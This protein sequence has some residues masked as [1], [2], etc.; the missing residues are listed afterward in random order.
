[1]MLEFFCASIQSYISV[2][3][4]YIDTAVICIFCCSDRK[5]GIAFSERKD[6]VA[7]FNVNAGE[8]CSRGNGAQVLLQVQ[9]NSRKN[10]RGGE[11]RERAVDRDGGDA[12]SGQA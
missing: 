9:G 1:M 4:L 12:G 8:Y 3:S 5:N 7:D 10:R 2:I 6:V 11:G